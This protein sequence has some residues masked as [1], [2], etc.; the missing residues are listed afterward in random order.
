[1]ALLGK[2]G[3]EPL[4]N[5]LGCFEIR[6]GFAEGVDFLFKGIEITRLVGAANQE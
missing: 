4:D 6:V 1:M 2:I 3:T 5:G